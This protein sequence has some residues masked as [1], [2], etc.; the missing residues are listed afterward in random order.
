MTKFLIAAAFL[1]SAPFV[2]A[3]DKPKAKPCSKLF[4]EWNFSKAERTPASAED[5]K[6]KIMSAI[7]SENDPERLRVISR[8]LLD[9]ATAESSERDIQLAYITVLID[10]G[11]DL[12]RFLT[13]CTDG[14]S[15]LFKDK[16]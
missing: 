6:K 15:A 4:S 2:H 16:K 10:R 14:A 3:Q 7:S 9:A 11:A 1:F 5:S 12:K 8:A 13:D